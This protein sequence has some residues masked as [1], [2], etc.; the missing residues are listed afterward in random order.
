[1]TMIDSHLCALRYFVRLLKY[2][3]GYVYRGVPGWAHASDIRDAYPR[4]RWAE[5]CY[6]LFGRGF[7]L[8]CTASQPTATKP[9]YIYRI[10]RLGAAAYGDVVGQLIAAPCAPGPPD[11]SPPLYV[12]RAGC[13]IMHSLRE[14]SIP[15]SAARTVH[16]RGG[17][18]TAAE[19]RKPHK[20]WNAQHATP[21]NYRSFCDTDL[22]ALN[23][24]GLIERSDYRLAFGRKKPIVIYRAT[25]SGRI[26]RLLEWVGPKPEHEDWRSHAGA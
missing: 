15:G 5:V 22:L 11:A 2:D 12:S 9:N 16:G 3:A 1:M 21:G 26:S 24:S 6:S 8:Q 25:D 4:Q 10:A 13:W 20:E 7:L 14:A 23:R 18:L 19:I 17:W